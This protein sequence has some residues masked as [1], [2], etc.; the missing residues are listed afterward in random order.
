MAMATMPEGNYST[1]FEVSYN[2]L[3]CS[4]RLIDSLIDPK[5]KNL[6][7]YKKLHIIIRNF[8]QPVYN[9]PHRYAE[10]AGQF[11]SA[12][13]CVYSHDHFAHGRSGPFSLDSPSRCQAQDLSAL[14][15]DITHRL[16]IVRRRHPSTTKCFL[17]AH[18]FGGLLGLKLA[19]DF[20]ETFD[21]LIL[22]APALVAHSES[23]GW[24]TIAA[25]KVLN[26]FM[27]NFKITDENHH[28][29]TR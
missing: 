10:L 22:Q 20:P 23:A 28:F 11:L 12:G 9:S 4:L 24:F 27:P 3:S 13:G 17:Y 5:S 18:S 15:R 16:A 14:I 7:A 25:A 8:Y 6:G 19:L 29:V 21:N 2:S 1:Y 26:L